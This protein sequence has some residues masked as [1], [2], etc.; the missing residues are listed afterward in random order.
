MILMFLSLSQ[1]QFGCNFYIFKFFFVCNFYN[2]LYSCVHRLKMMYLNFFSLILDF[3]I[4]IVD[5]IL[6]RILNLCS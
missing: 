2:T 5:L 4:V 6:I 1:D 3:I